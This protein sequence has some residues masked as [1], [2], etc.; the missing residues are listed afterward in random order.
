[1]REE[2]TRGLGTSV[3]NSILN[4]RA[5]L[6]GLSGS[7]ELQFFPNSIQCIVEDQQYPFFRQC[8]IA[9]S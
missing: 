5:S 7:Y 6:I 2:N 4:Y 3:S 1:M 8:N 9:I